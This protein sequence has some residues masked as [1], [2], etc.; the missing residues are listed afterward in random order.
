MCC[1]DRSHIY[2]TCTED[3]LAVRHSCRRRHGIC[4][5]ESVRGTKL[6]AY[7]ACSKCAVVA[8]THVFCRSK[9]SVQ[10]PA[11][12]MA[13]WCADMQRHPYV[14]EAMTPSFSACRGID[15]VVANPVVIHVCLHINTHMCV[16]NRGFCSDGAGNHLYVA[17]PRTPNF[18]NLH[19]FCHREMQDEFCDQF[20]CL[21]THV[22]FAVVMGSV[23]VLGC[24]FEN[25]P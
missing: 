4:C 16:A 2:C 9:E 17:E 19:V 13:G 18:K 8:D 24:L 7:F 15:S 21:R 10:F 12:L 20:S 22:C 14:A 6:F 25:A 23:A 5:H 11:A 3:S 1:Q